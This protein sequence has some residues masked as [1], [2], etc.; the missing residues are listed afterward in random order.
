MYTALI[1]PCSPQWWWWLL[2]TPEVATHQ[3]NSQPPQPVTWF[4]KTLSFLQTEI[5][6]SWWN[7]SGQ[8][9]TPG[10]GFAV[11]HLTIWTSTD[12]EWP[13]TR[14]IILHQKQIER[15]LS[16][17]NNALFSQSSHSHSA[18]FMCYLGLTLHSKYT[19]TGKLQWSRLIPMQC[20][21]VDLYFPSCKV[22]CEE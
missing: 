17:T 9:I 7:R 21:S 16:P 6:E 12:A 1:C 4:V 8:G 22:S 18:N 14:V 15:S 10:I 20:P 2:I 19:W 13:E 11:H 5:M 3:A